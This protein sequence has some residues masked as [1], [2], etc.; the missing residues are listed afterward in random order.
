MRLHRLEV[1]PDDPDEK[2]RMK[3]QWKRVWEDALYQFR[4]GVATYKH[5]RVTFLCE[6]AVD[7]GG[8]LREFLH[9]LVSSITH[10]NTLF[11]GAVNQRAPLHNMVELE[12]NTYY[13]VGAML[14]TSIVHGGPP[15]CVFSNVV[16]D[17]LLYGMRKTKPTIADIPDNTI[18]QKLIKV[19]QLA[20]MNIY[21]CLKAGR[22]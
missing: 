2:Y 21:Y 14:A 16:A 8:P 1:L 12:K 13:Y 10:N 18:Q 3:V 5:L 4:H 19:L 9:L 7:T 11:V 15:P 22:F 6:P 17:Y 20:L